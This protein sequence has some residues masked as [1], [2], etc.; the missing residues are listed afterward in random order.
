ME[1]LIREL[2]KI[3]KSIK[4]HNSRTAAQDGESGSVDE[5][6]PEDGPKEEES[7]DNKVDSTDLKDLG[8]DDTDT[9]FDKLKAPYRDADTD[10]D[11]P[12]ESEESDD[13][14]YEA[15]PKEQRIEKKK[16]KYEALLEARRVDNIVRTAVEALVT[17]LRDGI[18]R[19]QDQFVYKVKV[20]NIP[21]ESISTHTLARF[22]RYKDPV[23]KFV[24]DIDPTMQ[25][26]DWDITFHGKDLYMT[27]V[28]D[29]SAR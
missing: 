11:S 26:V 16:K 2:S 27:F 29:T 20:E 12:P 8:F 15:D 17:G 9:N 4:R 13:F 23:T 6:P 1:D 19:G 22:D 28:V 25:Q 24:Q 21:W 18:S 5:I 10:E 3:A 14:A 7:E